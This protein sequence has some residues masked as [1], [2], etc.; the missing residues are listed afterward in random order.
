MFPFPL[1]TTPTLLPWV[2]DTH[3]TVYS[4][5]EIRLLSYSM[6][7]LVSLQ[8]TTIYRRAV[9]HT[10]T[11]ALICSVGDLFGNMMRD[12]VRAHGHTK[13]HAART[14]GCTRGQCSA[15]CGRRNLYHGMGLEWEN[16]R[17]SG[18]LRDHLT[19]LKGYELCYNTIN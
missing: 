9:A 11:Y 6:R 8:A 10:T 4:G 12:C 1:P 5:W 14:A 16:L 19:C 18:G 17:T 3:K 13:S 2:S 15:S 7:L